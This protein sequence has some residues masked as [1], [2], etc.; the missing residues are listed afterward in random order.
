LIQVGQEGNKDFPMIIIANKIDLKEERVVSRKEL[1][2]RPCSII[3]YFIII[4]FIY[5]ADKGTRVG[6]L[7][8]RATAVFSLRQTPKQL[9]CRP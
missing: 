3:Y 4:I 1:Q 5:V 6:G 7:P 8:C 2:V 9:S